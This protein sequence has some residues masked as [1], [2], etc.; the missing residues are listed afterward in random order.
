MK[1][2]ITMKS[3]TYIFVYSAN[4]SEEHNRNTTF[5]KFMIRAPQT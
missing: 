4:L 1:R 5:M 3:S 2:N